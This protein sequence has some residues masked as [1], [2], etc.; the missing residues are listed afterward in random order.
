[1]PR[2]PSH[3]IGQ[4]FYGKPL[5]PIHSATLTLLAPASRGTYLSPAMR[6]V[7]T[8]ML[9]WSEDWSRLSNGRRGMSA[10]EIADRTS[11]TEQQVRNTMAKLVDVQLVREFADGWELTLER[12]KDAVLKPWVASANFRKV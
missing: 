1:M 5:H 11:L 4:G 2:R 10:A 9:L 8:M 3:P 6:L 12:W 7:A